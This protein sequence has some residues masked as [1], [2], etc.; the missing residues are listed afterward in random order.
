MWLVLGGIGFV[1]LIGALG[2]TPPSER[3]KDKSA[4]ELCWKEQQRKSLTSAEQRFIAGSCEYMEREYEKK[5][6]AKP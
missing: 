6:G 2:N 4:I 1:L 5:H 3:S